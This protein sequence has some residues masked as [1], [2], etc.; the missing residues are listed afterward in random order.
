MQKAEAAHLEAAGTRVRRMMVD[1]EFKKRTYSELN[2]DGDHGGLEYARRREELARLHDLPIVEGK[3]S[4]S[5]L[6]IE[7]EAA[8]GSLAHRFRACYRGLPA[9]P[10]APEDSCRFQDARRQRHQ[11]GNIEPNGKA[12]N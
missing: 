7:Y 3:I 4:L 9:P 11:L 1:F 6:R 12:G 10:Y 5:V 2:K 8:E